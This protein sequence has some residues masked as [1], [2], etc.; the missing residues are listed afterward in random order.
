MLDTGENPEAPQPR[1]MIDLEVST[2]SSSSA[3]AIF[4]SLLTQQQRKMVVFSVVFF[5]T[6]LHIFLG[7][8]SEFQVC[9]LSFTKL[10]ATNPKCFALLLVFLL[11]LEIPDIWN[12]FMHDKSRQNSLQNSQGNI[13]LD[14]RYPRQTV[15]AFWKTTIICPL[16]QNKQKTVK[17]QADLRMS[18][19]RIFPGRIRNL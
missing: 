5:S 16:H 8:I 1:E 6:V 9:C 7:T 18:C 12:L 14:K 17:I 19:I 15:R 2:S 10:N 13:F 4:L 11:S 3:L